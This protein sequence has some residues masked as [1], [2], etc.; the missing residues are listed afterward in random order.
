MKIE[1][2]LKDIEEK[3]TSPNDKINEYCDRLRNAIDL[4]TEIL[5]EKLNTFRG[6]LL[7]EVKAYEKGCLKSVSFVEG[8][9]SG[10]FFKEIGENNKKLNEFLRYLNQAKIDEAQVR[11]L[12]G[13]AKIQEYTLKN[14]LKVLD[15]KL[16]GESLIR[17]ENCQLDLDAS[18][19]GR[20]KY[21]DLTM[22]DNMIDIE[23]LDC[24]SVE[25]TINCPADQVLPLVGD[26]YL[27]SCET[28]LK[29]IDES[30]QN[31]VEIRFDHNPETF[32]FNNKDLILVQH[33]RNVW[34]N[35]RKERNCFSSLS[36][37]DL[38][39]D[40]KFEITTDYLII[41]SVSTSHNV[42]IQSERNNLI[43]VYNW[44]LEKIISLGQ[45]LYVDKPY[46]FNDCL[47]KL[48]KDDKIY[49]KQSSASSGERTFFI[50][51]VSLT[52]GELVSQ[53]LLDSNHDLFFIDA[54]SRTI[55]ID[56]KSSRLKIYDKPKNKFDHVD[57]IY[58][59]Q[60]TL[61]ADAAAFRITTDGRLFF[62]KNKQLIQFL[63]LCK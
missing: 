6:Q 58:D 53:Y 24:L 60:M 26:K 52:S 7:D 39:L 38:N 21:E 54:L 57:L 49:L 1:K 48:V 42:F 31:L 17:F 45:V 30:S 50:R 32:L 19:I 46:F 37:Y 18:I 35:N 8:A 62:I 55:A 56:V 23:K 33:T 15:N 3:L 41:S 59:K 47:L 29:V 63:S 51:V 14:I 40:L 16:F 10:R 9:T 5:I 28:G 22:A 43:N 36:V 4:Q 11:T 34:R 12:M 20:L 27:I 44:S 13:E 61:V 2:D 25:K